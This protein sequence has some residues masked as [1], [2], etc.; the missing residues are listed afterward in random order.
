ME[1]SSEFVVDFPTLGDLGDAWITRHCRVPDGFTRG[2]PFQMADWQFWCH[3]N[4]YRIRPDAVFVPPELVGPD[5][6]P[7]LNQAFFYQQTLVV[8][9]QKTGKGPFSAAQVAFE[10]AGPSVFAGWAEGGEVYS[11]ADN[12]C[13]CGWEDSPEAFVYAKGEPMGMRHPSPL[14]QI[15]AN[16]AEQ[17]D[18]IYK[19]LRAMI[20]LGPLKQLLAVREGFIR[21]LGLSDQDDLDRIDVVTSSARSRLGNPISDAEQD[22]AGLYT[23]S[24][25]MVD[26]ADTQARGAAG[27]GGRTHLTTNAW[28]PSENSYAQMIYEA[29]EPDVFIFYRDPD[30]ELRGDDGRPLDYKKL[31]DRR[32]IHEYA[33][34]GSWWVNLDSIEALAR[35]LMKRDPEQA[36][37]FFGNRLVAGHGKWLED[38]A[39]ESKAVPALV[40]PRRAPVAGGFDGSNNDDHTGIRLELLPTQYQFT[41]T[42]GPDERKT[43]WNPADYG[44]RIPRS[45]V[46]AAW[47][48]LA[49]F[50]DLVRVYLDP[51]FWQ[52]EI[53]ELAAEFGETVFIPWATNRPVPMHAALDRLKTDLGN[54]DSSFSHDGD[55]VVR[56]H[57][58]NA[59]IR[60]T[61][62]DKTTGVKRYVIGKPFGEEH[63]KIDFAMS[64][65]LAHEAAMDV[66]ASGWK[67]RTSS[68]VRVWR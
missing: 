66:L 11:C 5:K 54:D 17:A 57:M 27:M 16:S 21:I 18:N 46:M 6:P 20:N 52:S 1:M 44:N 2:R 29:N 4:R 30:K 19:P 60:P 10:A 47:R 15:T 24:N 41:P 50:Y 32:R 42:Y 45:E 7:V 28:D 67:P 61:T 40:I 63:R 62:V 49:K 31:A 33:Y 25:K 38:G 65:V 34:E 58:R 35:K 37:R 8:A 64:S 12:G 59:R 39:W 26:V 68:R 51:F 56:T 9:P 53:D 23:K 13:P 43:L 55:E 14:I 36:E 48:E 22:E 3:A